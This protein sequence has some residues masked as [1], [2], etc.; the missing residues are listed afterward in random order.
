MTEGKSGLVSGDMDRNQE[1]GGGLVKPGGHARLEMMLLAMDD[2]VPRRFGA[3]SRSFWLPLLLCAS[4]AQAA[5]IRASNDPVRDERP[6]TGEDRQHWAWRELAVPRVQHLAPS[7]ALDA[8]VLEKT[9]LAGA[10]DAATLIRRVTFDLTGLP[11]SPG[12]AREFIEGLI[13]YEA[14]VDRL[15]ASP[16]H[17]EHWAQWWLDLARYAETD[18]FEHDRERPRAW[19]YRDWVIAAL[20]ADMRFDEF[21]QKQIAGDLMGD[22]TGTGFLFSCP[23]MPDLNNQDERRHMVLNDITSTVGS[24]F[25]GLT[26]GCAQCHD[27][28]YDPVS[29]ADF[30][31]LR[32]F[33]DNTVLPQR[34]K[35]LGPAARVFAEGVPASTVYVRGELRRPG[36][37]VAPAFPRI[38]LRDP[39]PAENPDRLA[40]ARWITRRD[41]VLFLRTMAN[42][43]WQQHFGRPLAGNPADLGHQGEAPSHPA[44]LDWLAAE[45]PRQNWSLKR[46]HKTIVMSRTYRQATPQQRRLTGEM[47]RDTLLSVAGELNLKTGGESVRLPMPRE[48]KET[49][50]KKQAEVTED[51][52]EQ[53]RRSIYTFARRNARHPVLDLFDRP[54]ALTSCA[55]R[56]EST[57]APQALLMLNSDIMHETAAKLAARLTG[58]HG[59]EAALILADACWI[60]LSRAPHADEVERGRVFLDSQAALAGNF[61]S[62]VQ[63]YCLALLNS[64]AFMFVD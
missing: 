29:Q 21:V 5:A 57:T 48:I 46:L 59:S 8:V 58:R 62:A 37:V 2:A 64:N 51:A 63:D 34:D 25:L 49:L 60:C 1:A 40:L 4:H 12:E 23:D 6:I 18:G 43:L 27:H 31:R 39:A 47:L 24:V 3:V 35:Q 26:M 17:G 52:A 36:P 38:A 32:A 44:L 50:L 19:Q 55:R 42:R 22:E 16:R 10:A 7:A 14:V 33:F 28:V 15:L 9:P 61:A 30:Y 41:N 13:S 20:N 53:R 45:L 54:D 11:P 56:N